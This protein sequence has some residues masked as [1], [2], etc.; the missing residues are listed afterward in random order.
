MSKKS[1]IES[2]STVNTGQQTDL[3]IDPILCD[4]PTVTTHY[5][6]EP[7]TYDLQLMI[8]SRARIVRWLAFF[9]I[10]FLSISLIVSINNN[11]INQNTLWIYLVLFPLC[12]CVCIGAIKYNK[13]QIL[14]YN[15]YLFCM[16][17]F[18]IMLSVYYSNFVWFIFTFIE[19]YFFFYV[20]RL[21]HFL[22][23]A[24]ES[25][26]ESLQSGW[27]PTLITYYYY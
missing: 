23:Y 4:Y 2:Q 9:D 8:Y 19:I 12:I 11:N 26:I 10:L 7:P 24:P 21:L 3:M 25:I 27:N 14:P 18:Y 5:S 15:I 13:Y 1:N 22:H 20:T 17:I 6:I 16:S